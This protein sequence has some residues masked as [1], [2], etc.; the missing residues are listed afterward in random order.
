MIILDTNVVSEWMS[1]QA[2][3]RALAWL[4]QQPELELAT[5]VITIA[6]LATGIA[7]LPA[8]RRRRLIAEAFENARQQAFPAGVLGFNEAAALRVA[9]LIATRKRLGRPLDFADAQ[10]AAIA[11]EHEAVLATRNLRDFEGL[12]LKLINPFA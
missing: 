4:S 1:A 12:S 5:T 6:E 2:N 9:G 7:L 8:G 10:I 3:P 11:L